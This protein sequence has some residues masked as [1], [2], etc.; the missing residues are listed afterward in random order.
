MFPLI[1]A[2]LTKFPLVVRVAVYHMLGLTEASKFVDLRT[3]VTVAVLRAFLDPSKPQSITETQE[4]IANEVPIKGRIWISKYTAP[5]PEETSIRDSLVRVIEALRQ[6]G[7]SQTDIRLP[8]IAPV[9]AEWT[10]YR[11]GASPDGKLPA[12][13]EAEK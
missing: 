11:A 12:I 3:E 7:A 2:A 10:G 13:S 4:S 5:A 1:W 8:D 9:E 6:P